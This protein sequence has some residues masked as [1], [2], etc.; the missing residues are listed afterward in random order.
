MDHGK[1][2]KK[3]RWCEYHGYFHAELYYCKSY[4]RH[5]KKEIK[6]RTQIIQRQLQDPAW[7]QKQ[8]DAGLPYEGIVVWRI[9]AGL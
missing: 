2:Y 7:V 3:G 1:I 8:L 9:F 6:E 5:I 4:P